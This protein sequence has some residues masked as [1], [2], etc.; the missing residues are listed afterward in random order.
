MR[1]LFVAFFVFLL[2]FVF[3]VLAARWFGLDQR[4]RKVKSKNRASHHPPYRVEPPK[5]QLDSPPR[6]RKRECPLFYPEEIPP[7]R[8]A[9]GCPRNDQGNVVHNPEFCSALDSIIDNICG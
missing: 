7:L 5:T 9:C 1:Q 6:E 2:F 3:I 8:A 4:G